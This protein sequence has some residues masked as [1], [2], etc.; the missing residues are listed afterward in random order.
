MIVLQILL[1]LIILSV[2]VLVHELGHFL[3]AKKIGV[4][5]EEFGIGL[6]PRVWGKKIGETIYSVNA[7]PIGGF[8]RLHGEVGESQSEIKYPDRAFVNKG[9]LPRI[10]VAVAGV[11]MNVLFAVLCFGSIYV[12]TGVPQELAE[13]VQV[14]SIT[15]NSPAEEAGIAL[16][17]K[18]V[19]LNGQ[20]VTFENF[21]QLIEENKGNNVTLTFDN[22]STKEVSIR[23]EAPA[24]EGLMGVGFS[25]VEFS[26]P[27]WY[28]AP[29]EYLRLGVEDTFYWAKQTVLG[30]KMLFNDVSQGKAPEGVLGPVGITLTLAEFVKTG[31]VSV[32]GLTGIISINLAILNILPFPPL[33]GSRVVLIIAEKVFGKK[34]VRKHEAQIYVA[35]MAVLLVLIALMTLSEIPRLISAGSVT[36]FV[37]SILQ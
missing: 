34:N 24:G 23:E 17:S 10:A 30:F 14:T 20:T 11:V 1:A 25:S 22:G 19:A 31:I 33:D 21:G 6:P 13:G 5:A 37:E 16:E 29:F 12:F 28:K 7:L 2:L 35:G 15:P 3:V 18:V 27:V 8:V 36:G 32:L 4:W 9:A 26:H